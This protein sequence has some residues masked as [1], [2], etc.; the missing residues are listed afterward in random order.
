MLCSLQCR[1]TVLGI[2]DPSLRCILGIHVQSVEKNPCRIL[3]L[4]NI[5]S[6]ILLLF[7]YIS[8]I[9]VKILKKHIQ[10]SPILMLLMTI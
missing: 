7:P 1:A 6:Y 4:V 3:L 2:P 5:S 9:V 8:F 10:V